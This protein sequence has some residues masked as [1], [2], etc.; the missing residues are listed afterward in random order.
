GDVVPGIAAEGGGGRSVAKPVLDAGLG[1][2]ACLDAG[3]DLGIGQ[4]AAL[5]D[6]GGAGDQNRGRG[7]EGSSQE[8]HVLYD[9]VPWRPC[10][11][12]V[13]ASALGGCKSCH[14]WNRSMRRIS[15]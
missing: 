2:A 4:V 1:I 7:Q 3:L 5:V 6:H 12:P 14:P 11:T 8:F 10:C 13:L 15:C 9:V